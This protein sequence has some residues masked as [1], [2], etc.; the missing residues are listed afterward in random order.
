MRFFCQ[1]H[2]EP[3]EIQLSDKYCPE[4]K[5]ELYWIPYFDGRDRVGVVTYPIW[6][7]KGSV[8]KL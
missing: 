5:Q 6:P 2:A 8:I 1:N 7:R 4:C 3:V